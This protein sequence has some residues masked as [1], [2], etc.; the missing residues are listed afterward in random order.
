MEDEKKIGEN[1][2]FEHDTVQETAVEFEKIRNE[3]DTA[4]YS[5]R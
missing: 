4:E 1:V 3:Y 5:V 2:P